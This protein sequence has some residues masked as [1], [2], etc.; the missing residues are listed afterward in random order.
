MLRFIRLQECSVF[1]CLFYPLGPSSWL[2]FDMVTSQQASYLQ[3]LIL[4]CWFCCHFYL[5]QTETVVTSES[6]LIQASTQALYRTRSSSNMITDTSL[7]F[8]RSRKSRVQ[9]VFLNMTKL[10]IKIIKFL[11]PEMELQQLVN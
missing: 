7:S 8:I 9:I 10:T 11:A 5:G 4:V 3:I 6:D 1:V 2:N